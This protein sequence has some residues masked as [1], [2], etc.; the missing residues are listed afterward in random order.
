MGLILIH[1]ILLC[2]V[3]EPVRVLL[4]SFPF[5]DSS[6]E[7]VAYQIQSHECLKK[8]N[9]LT[10]Y[11]Y[12]SMYKTISNILLRYHDRFLHRKT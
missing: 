7:D 6:V 8:Y 9:L 10:V 12:T 1:F 5:L 3:F 4:I 2:K 11:V